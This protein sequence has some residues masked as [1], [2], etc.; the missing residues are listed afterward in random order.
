MLVFEERGKPEYPEKNLSEQSRQRTNSAHLWRR[1][2][3]SNPGHI[4]GRRVLYHCANPDPQNDWR[5]PN[6]CDYNILT[7]RYRSFRQ[8]DWLLTQHRYCPLWKNRIFGRNRKIA[9]SL[10]SCRQLAFYPALGYVVK[11]QPPN[12]IWAISFIW[13]EKHGRYWF[14]GVH[15]FRDGSSRKAARF[16]ESAM[17]KDEY[18]YIFLTSNGF[19]CVCLLSFKYFRCKCTCDDDRA[20][21]W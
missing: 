12:D 15:N 8:C 16:E 7:K 18:A 19:F 14:P 13:R 6:D 10:V 17:S 20:H 1:V 2:R 3:K 11:S 4:G 5:H 21:V 9:L